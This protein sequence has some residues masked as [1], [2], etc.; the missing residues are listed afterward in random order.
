MAEQQSKPAFLLEWVAAYYTR[1]DTLSYLH[2]R[3]LFDAFAGS[4]REVVTLD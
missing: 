1:A 4:K 3:R 2:H